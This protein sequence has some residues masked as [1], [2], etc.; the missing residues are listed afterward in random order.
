MWCNM[1]RQGSISLLCCEFRHSCVP[2][3][4]PLF[5]PMLLFCHISSTVYCCSFL[6]FVSLPSLLFPSLSF[7]LH[8]SSVFLFLRH[9]LGHSLPLLTVFTYH[10]FL[11][12]CVISLSPFGCFINVLCPKFLGYLF[13]FISHIICLSFCVFVSF[14]FVHS[15]SLWNWWWVLHGFPY[16]LFLLVNSAGQITLM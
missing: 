10:V 3:Y 4:V 5:S 16:I 1:W 7:M 14:F 9:R 2:Q 11:D 8:F 13:Y 6:C 12:W 15:G